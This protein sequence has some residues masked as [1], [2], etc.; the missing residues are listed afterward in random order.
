MSYSLSC[1]IEVKKNGRWDYHEFQHREPLAYTYAPF[2]Y[3]A[4]EF[5]THYRMES[6]MPR[7]PEHM[8]S[9]GLPEDSDWLKEPS[10]ESH[11][12]FN[13]TNAQT[14]FFDGSHY[15][16]YLSLEELLSFD[17]DQTY[18]DLN[19]TEYD[20]H[21]DRR[22]LSPGEGRE[23][24]LRESLGK[25][26]FHALEYLKELGSPQDVRILFALI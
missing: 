22:Y 6:G 21:D 4:M 3:D 8:V 11:A 10:Q 23:M 15:I 7:I 2:D 18:E 13:E 1:H 16:S 5:F 26:Y 19:K 20:P 17:Y 12:W 14:L 24:T 9:R 25:S